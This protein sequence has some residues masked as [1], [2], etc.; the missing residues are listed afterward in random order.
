[1]KQF[2]YIMVLSLIAAC[3]PAG[4]RN[5]ERT[6]IVNTSTIDAPKESV[7]L[8]SLEWFAVKGIP[9]EHI[10]KESGIIASKFGGLTANKGYG[11]GN[12]G[13]DKTHISCGEPTGNIGLYRARF[14]SSSINMNVVLRAVNDSQTK[15]V[16]TVG[17]HAI[18]QVSNLYGVVSKAQT[19]CASR[20]ILEAEFLNFLKS[21]A[22]A[23]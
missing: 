13:L 19:P 1:M 6:S 15:V 9:M 21:R 20:G 8:D 10:N 7:W 18:S 23:G 14:V 17:G 4:S 12:E 5:I 22:I 3:S 2:S 11:I 16:I